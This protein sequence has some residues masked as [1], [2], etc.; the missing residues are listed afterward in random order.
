MSET[1]IAA[2]SYDGP[3]QTLGKTAL[4]L[5][6]QV[7]LTSGR[8]VVIET[9]AGLAIIDP[10]DERIFRMG[11]AIGP[12]AELL[13]E[14]DRTGKRLSSILVTHAH[15]DHVI[16]LSPLLD[17]GRADLR[18]GSPQ[19]IASVRSPLA[20]TVA[21]SEPTVLDAESGLCAI[22]LSGHSPW[23]DD[24]AFYHP[25]SKILFPGDLIQPKGERWEEAFYPSPWPWF[26]DGGAYLASL[27]ALLALD[28]E[29]LA[30]GH[31][32]IRFKP[33]G[34]GWVELT[35]RAIARV[36]EEVE[37]W[38]GPDDPLQAGRAI[39]RKLAAERGIDEET[40]AARMSP[41][42][43]SVFDRFDLPGVLYF[44]N[45]RGR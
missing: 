15:P 14:C 16:N 32:E 20:G 33:E 36:R 42:G 6:P 2:K 7:L 9:S 4:R 43:E 18:I 39:F 10:G 23:G 11:E 29:T 13:A 26:T 19:V 5:A 25:P 44:W 12:L 35:R 22:P 17:Y 1:T 21:I 8:T 45:R 31:R 27:D 30:T 37:G 40:V 34:R 28:F 24:L 41:P 3:A 38:S